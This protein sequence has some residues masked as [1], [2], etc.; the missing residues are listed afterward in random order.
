MLDDG[1]QEPLPARRMSAPSATTRSASHGSSVSSSPADGASVLIRVLRTA[2]P[3]SHR[4][5][6]LVLHQVDAVVGAGVAPQGIAGG[7]QVQ[8]R[9]PDHLLE[10]EPAGEREPGGVVVDGDASAAGGGL[11]GVRS[12]WRLGAVRGVGDDDAATGLPGEVE[13][14]VPERRPDAASSPVRVHADV[15]DGQVRVAHQ[16][17]ADHGPADDG[18]GLAWAPAGTATSRCTVRCGSV[19][20]ARG[21]DVEGEVGRAV[22][23]EVD[24]VPDLDRPLDRPGVGVVRVRGDVHEVDHPVS[25]VPVPAAGNVNAPSPPTRYASMRSNAPTQ[26]CSAKKSRTS[27]DGN[28]VCTTVMSV[29]PSTASNV[30]SMCVVMVM[31][32][33]A[34]AG[35]LGDQAVRAVDDE[36][37]LGLAEEGVAVG[38]PHGGLLAADAQVDLDLHDAGLVVEDREPD[39]LLLGVG[40][41]V[42]HLAPGWRAGRASCAARGCVSVVMSPC[43]SAG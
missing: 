28:P 26:A 12:G 33:G 27:T 21:G 9:V 2:R 43:L 25:L 7:R 42:E 41:G 37:R 4:R 22:D 14:G 23:R 20:V 40:V 32:S 17:Q 29:P 10:R 19:S 18:R 36:E 34:A 1:H 30:I 24:G 39:L 3:S 11:E 35:R 38:P 16:W 8:H 13:A 6:E 15:D 31:P 5:R